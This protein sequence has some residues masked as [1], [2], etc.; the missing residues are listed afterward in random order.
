MDERFREDKAK[1]HIDRLDFIDEQLQENM[2][3]PHFDT[4]EEQADDAAESLLLD[5]YVLIGLFA[6]LYL[7]LLIYAFIRN[8]QFVYYLIPAFL[9]LAYIIY[10]RITI[11]SGIK[12]LSLLKAS[13]MSGS[14][15]NQS[16]I[17]ELKEQKEAA[18]LD[19][20]TSELLR[21]YYIIFFPLF[22]FYLMDTFAANYES[23]YKWFIFILFA[24]GSAVFWWLL[25][26]KDIEAHQTSID[27]YTRKITEVLASSSS[28][29]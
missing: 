5:S 21:N 19:Y 16:L 3:N 13:E 7:A 27:A 18:K 9:I 28:A 17:N 25:F 10:F 26:Q 24:L 23:G 6:L 14:A 15:N 22:L 20:T 4:E 12:K 1:K 2:E 29:G 11:T 8:G